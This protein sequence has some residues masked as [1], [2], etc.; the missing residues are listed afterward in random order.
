MSLEMILDV[1]EVSKVQSDS[2]QSLDTDW[3]FQVAKECQQVFKS[4]FRQLMEKQQNHTLTNR[5]LQY[6][7]SLPRDIY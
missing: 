3:L 7:L 2:E 6:I 5:Q 4:G 1:V